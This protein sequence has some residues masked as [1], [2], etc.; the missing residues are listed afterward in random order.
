MHPQ[1]ELGARVLIQTR[2]KDLRLSGISIEQTSICVRACACVRVCVY[3][4][5]QFIL[6][7]IQHS[8]RIM[9]SHHPCHYI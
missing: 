1:T 5:L 4:A 9:T 6:H 8:S 7:N 2:I 3:F